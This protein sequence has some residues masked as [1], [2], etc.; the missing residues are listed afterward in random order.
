MLYAYA[1][2]VNPEAIYKAIDTI[3]N[4]AKEQGYD[5]PPIYGLMITG[6]GGA[7]KTAAVA[8]FAY[9]ESEVTWLSGP[10]DTQIK[11]LKKVATK[12]I[13]KSKEDLLNYILGGKSIDFIIK[14]KKGLDER[15]V[16][17]VTSSDLNIANAPNHLIIDEVTHFSNAEL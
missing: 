15:S 12:G 10:T 6:I 2:K 3:A 8:N 17:N 16:L 5:M 1:L 13:A 11:G 7:G 14:K 9:N 4:Y